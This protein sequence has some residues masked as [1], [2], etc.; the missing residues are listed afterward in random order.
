MNLVAYEYIASQEKRHGVLI[1]SEFT[2]AAQSLTRGLIVNP[3]NTE[4]LADA[5]HDAV[6]MGEEQR[7]NNYEVLRD[8]INKYT[9]YV[10]SYFLPKSGD[11]TDISSAWWGKTFVDTLNDVCKTRDAHRNKGVASPEGPTYNVKTPKQEGA[12]AVSFQLDEDHEVGT[13]QQHQDFMEKQAAAITAKD[14]DDSTPTPG[15]PVQRGEIVGP[16]GQP[17]PH[18]VKSPEQIDGQ[19]EEGSKSPAANGAA[20]S[21]VKSKS[22]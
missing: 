6:T 8:Y 4:E 12:K 9:R 5:V 11:H 20:V 2:G 16:N 3:W 15:S 17:I 1:L 10:Q 19:G 21:P 13:T 7:K 22:M 18:R 14:F